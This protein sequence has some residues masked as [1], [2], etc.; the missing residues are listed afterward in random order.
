MNCMK[1]NVKQ[2]FK[3]S[4][5]LLLLFPIIFISIIACNKT[6]NKAIIITEKLSYV[7]IGTT[8]AIIEVP[9]YIADKFLFYLDKNK[10]V[11][12]K[13]IDNITNEEYLMDINEVENGLEKVQYQNQQLKKRKLKLKFNYLND[14]TIK[15]SFA[16]LKLN[17]ENNEEHILDI[18][19]VVFIKK[20]TASYLD[21]E[22]TKCIVNDIIPVNKELLPSTVGIVV[23][24]NCHN[25][26]GTKINRIELLN[27]YG[28]IDNSQIKIMDSFDFDNQVN[29]N[30]FLTYE[31]MKKGEE[32][33]CK[34]EINEDKPI[35]LLLPITY[36]QLNQI[37]KAGLI[38]TF[39]NGEKQMIDEFPLFSSTKILNNY[40][41]YIINSSK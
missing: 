22:R 18:G 16:K 25:K 9:I 4:Y 21:I 31:L 39:E 2:V 1:K 20:Q 38:I 41:E 5:F 15:I 23:Q 14:Q 3:Y 30:N 19:S 35:I 32:I 37:Y 24:I 7:G 26:I 12:C 34:L 13:I 27:G 40:D 33:D 28:Y 29:I 6:K 17:Y 11:S 8:S 10:I 36:S